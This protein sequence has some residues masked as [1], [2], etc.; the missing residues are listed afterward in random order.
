MITAKEARDLVDSSEKALARR[1]DLIE[2]AIMD[3]AAKGETEFLLDYALPYSE[4]FKFA[5][6]YG[7]SE[8]RLEPRVV[9]VL[10]A[11]KQHGY[12]TKLVSR[13]HDGTAGGRIE[14]HE[15]V[16]FTTWHI[17]VKW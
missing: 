16:P 1:L 17:Q 15:A 14:D 11:L 9:Q 5:H 7:Y 3:T 6:S 10:N 2:K 13:Q 12:Q 4:E 8:P